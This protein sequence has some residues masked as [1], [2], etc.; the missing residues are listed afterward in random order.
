MTERAE[1]RRRAGRPLAWPRWGALALLFVAEV[2]LLSVRFDTA[3][4]S[5]VSGEWAM[6]VAVTPRLIRLA[7]VAVAVA[8][9]FHARALLDQLRVGWVWAANHGWAWF[10][11]LHVVSLLTF[12]WLTEEILEHG[13][14]AGRLAPAWVLAWFA[15]GV[16]SVAGWGLAALPAAIWRR[17]AASACSGLGVG[18]CIGAAVWASELTADGLWQPLAR[19]TLWCAA[20]LLALV[21]PAVVYQPA[22]LVIGTPSFAVRID[23][24]CSGYEGMA[25]I[26]AFLSGYLWFDRDALR[27]PQ[28]LVLLPL[29]AAAS[30]VANVLRMTLLVAMGS[31]WSES[32]AMGGFH[33]QA[34]AIAFASIGLGLV[35]VA[36]R[37]TWFAKPASVAHGEA[38]NPT[39]AYLVPMLSV[40]AVGM[41]TG[42]FSHGVDGLYPLRVWAALGALWYFRN[43]YAAT[44]GGWPSQAVAKEGLEPDGL[45]RPSSQRCAGAAM[46]G[47]FAAFAMGAAVFAL[48]VL[49]APSGAATVGPAAELAA[50]PAAWRVVWWVSRTG[51]YLVIAPLVEELAFRGFLMRRLMAADFEA[52]SPRRIAWWAAGVSALAFAALHGRFWAAGALAGVAYGYA[53]SRRGSLSDAMLAHCVTN[54]LLLVCVLFTGNWSLL[55]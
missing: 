32:I 31:S 39:A 5:D 30:L 54:G 12:V 50:W 27:L 24:D 22:G 7:I 16:L 28:A 18:L 36:R 44:W 14:A 13:R 38:C 52:V 19:G 4:L 20:Q 47:L 21:Y 42:A 35:V 34:G 25:L 49:L 29:G 2:V 51:G 48:W 1:L 55:S 53:Y 37:S 15:S 45:G 3:S 40:I 8:L 33:S 26:L 43:S 17:L 6:A 11:A 10:L 23:P 9:V 46:R 41:L